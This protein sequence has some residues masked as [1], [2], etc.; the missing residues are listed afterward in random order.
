MSVYIISE[1]INED[2]IYHRYLKNSNTKIVIKEG[3]SEIIKK[4][5][6]EQAIKLF[7]NPKLKRLKT[8][9]EI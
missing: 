5:T 9:I 8:S 7:N 4:A 6:Q 2:Y 1:Y 3:L